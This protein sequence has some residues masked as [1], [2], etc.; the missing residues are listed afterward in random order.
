MPAGA[1]CDERA[2]AGDAQRQACGAAERGEDDS[3]GDSLPDDPRARRAER[4]PN[5][6]FLPPRRAACQ[7]QVR[8]VRARDEQHD[9]H[10]G[11][12]HPQRTAHVGESDFLKSHHDRALSLVGE[13][14]GPLPAQLS[15]DAIE[16][17]LYGC[18]IE[19]RAR[20]A[21][22]RVVRAQVAGIGAKA[23]RQDGLGR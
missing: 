3:L 15:E 8:D 21:D 11:E 10:A 5:R 17:R 16:I 1:R 22:D 14:L 12:Q 7:Q 6:Q 18:A 9:T 23:E 2:K 19:S 4:A 20:A 13:L